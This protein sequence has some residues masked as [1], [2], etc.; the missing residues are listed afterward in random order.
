MHQSFAGVCWL[1]CLRFCSLWFTLWSWCK[2]LL[3]CPSH[4]AMC[5]KQWINSSGVWCLQDGKTWP[6]ASFTGYAI[7]RT[8]TRDCLFYHPVS[9]MRESINRRRSTPPTHSTLWD[10]NFLSSKSSVHKI[11]MIY[12][13]KKYF[14]THARLKD[15]CRPSKKV[16]SQLQEHLAFNH[17][18]TCSVASVNPAGTAS[19]G[20][21]VLYGDMEAGEVYFHIEIGNEVLT[22]VEK[23]SHQNYDS[24]SCSATWQR[25]QQS[26]S[27]DTASIKCCMAYH[28][29]PNGKVVGLVPLAFRSSWKRKWVAVKHVKALWLLLEAFWLLSQSLLAAFQSHVAG[30]SKPV[31]C[32]SK[33]CGWFFQAF[34]LVSHLFQR[35]QLPDC[36]IQI[37][38][39]LHVQKVTLHNINHRNFEENKNI[40]FQILTLANHLANHLASLALSRLTT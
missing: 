6:T 4:M 20:D 31:G 1:H 35:F 40:K 36:F 26:V 28:N 24:S 17:V 34:W 39:L 2:Q 27:V 7:S 25:L 32:L 23:F 21:V 16:V 12:S 10:M 5:N 29:L 18:Y 13:K 38:V 11:C 37:S 15:R 8:I 3:W 9:A 19:K 30:F 14:A 22:L 33:P